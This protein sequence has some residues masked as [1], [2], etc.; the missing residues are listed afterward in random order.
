MNRAKGKAINH[1][2]HE[3]KT[4]VAILTGS[5]QIL[6]KKISALSGVN[7][8]STLN[9]IERN[10]E[11]IVDIQTETADIMETGSY[12]ARAM[13]IK[14]LETCGDE[15]ET[16][17][18][19]CL[20]QGI[21]DPQHLI[22][23]VS[24]LIDQEF[25]PRAMGLKNVD[26]KDEFHRTMTQMAP[27]YH[28]R[29]LDISIDM[30]DGLPEI[31]MPPEVVGKVIEGLIKNAI[32]NTPDQ[33]RLEISAQTCDKGILFKVQDFGVGILED[34]QQQ[35]FEGF[36]STQETLL[37]ST[38]T[39]YEFN[40]GGKGA[41]LL[42]IKLFSQRLGFTVDLSSQRCGFITEY[43][44]PCPGNIA[45]CRFCKD[46]EDCLGSGRTLFSVF[47]PNN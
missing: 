29:R 6:R 34:D 32:E 13:L 38:K 18:E 20:D 8:D 24:A 23:S 17:I 11:R 42:R 27:K 37:Y 1:L 7:L 4:P 2:S 40:A 19:S 30:P 41:D 39:P 26:F 46:Q 5:L 43:G 33:G 25:G 44:E 31:T 3:L 36:F 35:I 12:Q 15:L 45:N 14:M 28:F 21:V 16:L 9:R 22:Q 10:L 47:F